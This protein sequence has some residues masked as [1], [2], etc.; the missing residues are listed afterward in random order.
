MAK[1]QSE[2]AA[3]KQLLQLPAKDLFALFGDTPAISD[4]H[5]NM[6]RSGSH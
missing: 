5:H 4:R 6:E 3:I 1:A 2:D